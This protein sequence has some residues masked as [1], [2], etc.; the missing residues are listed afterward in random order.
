MP[1]T[2]A[3]DFQ[4]NR[5][6]NLPLIHKTEVKQR[7]LRDVMG[8]SETEQVTHLIRTSEVYLLLWL[9]FLALGPADRQLGEFILVS[10]E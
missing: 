6:F 7:H 4:T 3:C 10:V 8:P 1:A 5:S 2:A 9:L